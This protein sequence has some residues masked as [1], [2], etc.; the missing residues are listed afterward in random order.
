ML[1]TMK[2]IV[3]AAREGHYCVAAPNYN[4]VTQMH[5]ALAAAEEAKSPLILDIG[6]FFG[7]EDR[8]LFCDLCQTSRRAA[9][10]AS[11]PVAI[12]L[13]HGSKYDYIV[14][15]I[16]DG[17][18]SVMADRSGLPY[19]QN[20]AEVAELAR[21]AHA[22][23]VSIEAELGHVGTNEDGKALDGLQHHVET[24][25]EKRA[26]YTNPDQAIEYVEA[27][28]IDCLAVAVGTVHGFYPEGFVPSVDFELL[29][30]LRE[31][32]SVPLVIHGGSGSGDEILKG[33][34][35][36]ASKLNVGHDLFKA[37][38]DGIA[39][40]VKSGSGEDPVEAGSKAYT[41]ELVHYMTVLGSVGKA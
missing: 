35:P 27:T 3:D 22:L 1:V 23:G 19:E 36:Y 37:F 26:L 33:M 17:C 16:V 7:T 2:E 30:E 25:E 4:D 6:R 21:I 40:A 31:K 38:A 14:Q 41:A 32:V 39:E 28:G 24:E 15:S 11:V 12:N 8:E 34:A 13:D 29:A 5:A 18:T 9:E 20:V 10:R